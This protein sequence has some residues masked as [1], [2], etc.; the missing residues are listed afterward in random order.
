[1]WRHKKK[2]T[3]FEISFK[4]RFCS[5]VRRETVIDALGKLVGELV[6]DGSLVVDLSNPDYT[7]QIEVVQTLCGLSV[8]PQGR[9]YRKFN[10]IEL[11]ES[12]Y[13]EG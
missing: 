11:K 6:E 4:R 1:M 5:N 12:G 9:S 10:L 3:T 7:I 8:I 13:R 2:P